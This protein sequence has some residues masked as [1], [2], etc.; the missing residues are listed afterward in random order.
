MRSGAGADRERALEPGRRSRAGA[1]PAVGRVVGAT[2]ALGA[3]GAPG[4]AVA[5][6][7]A[8]STTVESSGAIDAAGSGTVVVS[9]SSIV[10]STCASGSDVVDAGSG[11]S[12]GCGSVGLGR[13][14]QRS[15]RRDQ[16]GEA[17]G[18]GDRHAP[19]GATRRVRLPRTPVA[20]PLGGRGCLGLGLDGSDRVGGLLVGGADRG[21]APW[22]CGRWRWNRPRHR[23][24]DRRSGRR[25]AATRPETG[26]SFFGG[27][28]GHRRP[29]FSTLMRPFS[30]VAWNSSSRW[31]AVLKNLI[32]T[33]RGPF[34]STCDTQF[35]C[36]ATEAT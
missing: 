35:D 10:A 6:S 22:R 33:V 34:L 8:G 24:V 7:G 16:T 36:R 19:S 29:Q 28:F 25:H 15:H 30:T 23:R 18:R 3:A 31:V 11:S 26:E 12:G 32:S 1:P 17:R 5:P 20:D 21:R 4:A 9:I 13:S 27:E 2:G 14:R